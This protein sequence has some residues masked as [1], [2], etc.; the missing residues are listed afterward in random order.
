MKRL[1]PDAP[2]AAV[3]ALVFRGD[4][5]LLI[6]RLG[7]PHRGRWSPPGGAV[8]LGETARHALVREVREETGLRVEPREVIDVIDVI[9]PGRGR[10][11]YHYVLAVFRARPVAGRLRAQSDAGEARWVP[12]RDLKA[13]NVTEATLAVVAKSRERRR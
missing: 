5:V 4:S 7:E 8:N 10:P 2:V 13:M 11:A 12:V 9:V 1:R 3:E 6:R